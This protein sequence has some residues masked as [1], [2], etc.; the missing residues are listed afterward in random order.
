MEK[1]GFEFAPT[2]MYM[3]NVDFDEL[4]EVLSVVN[5]YAISLGLEKKEPPALQKK[6]SVEFDPFKAGITSTNSEVPRI[7]EGSNDPLA[8]EEKR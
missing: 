2:L 4:S 3:K 8:L 7:A 1:M 6:Q 5:T